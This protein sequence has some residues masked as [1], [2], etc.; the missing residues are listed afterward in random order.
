MI[1]ILIVDDDP[2]VCRYIA[3]FF[4]ERGH[5]P[6]VV[7]DP[8][9]V[10][11]VAEKEKPQIVLLDILMEPVDGLAVLKQLKEKFQDALK[12]IMVSVADDQETIR[13]ARGLGAD[14][15]IE[16]PFDTTYLEEVVM[17]KIQELLHYRA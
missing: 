15:Y 3:D 7:T 16:K 9:K 13:R 5:A 12:V 10:L 8:Q 4:K 2:R 11:S 6:F 17:T 1:K 14:D